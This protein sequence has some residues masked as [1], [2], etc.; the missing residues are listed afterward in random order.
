[1]DRPLHSCVWP[2]ET[3]DTTL[4]G[5][6][7]NST[8]SVREEPFSHILVERVFIDPIY[9]QLLAAFRE[10]YP[11]NNSG[12]PEAARL[13]FHK[14]NF[15][16]YLMPFR[17]SLSGP[18]SLFVS[19]A[20]VDLLSKVTGVKATRDVNG[21]LHCHPKGSRDGFIHKDFSSC[22]F[23]DRPRPDGINVADNTICN[24]RTGET[25][26]SG[27][28]TQERVRAVAMI[29]YINNP[30]WSPGDGGETGLYRTDRDPIHQPAA[31]IPPVNNTMLIFE[32]SPHSRHSFISNLRNP[33]SNIVMWLH[34]T[35]LDT[36]ARWGEDS[37]VYV[38]G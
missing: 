32:C 23:V 5:Y 16:A 1:M 12:G 20:W 33:R 22:W 15:D 19:K 11:R 6:L 27:A 10:T 13:V 21:A 30:P 28:V 37:I 17:P 3:I 38:K 7:A 24:Y 2:Q 18:L 31:A 4:A 29:F 34:R 35:K 14:N 26:I 25:S 9:D 8:W 36:V